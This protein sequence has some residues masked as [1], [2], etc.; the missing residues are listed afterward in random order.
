MDVIALIFV[1][2]SSFCQLI[3][4]ALRYIP[5]SDAGPTPQSRFHRTSP[6][7]DA[8][9]VHRSLIFLSIPNTPHQSIPTPFL[10]REHHCRSYFMELLSYD[11]RIRLN[12]RRANAQAYDND[13]EPSIELTTLPIQFAHHGNGE[14]DISTERGQETVTVIHVVLSDLCSRPQSFRQVRSVK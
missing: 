3:M 2:Y 7:P 12:L 10:H 8:S 9:Y 11:E 6:C 5:L 14:S 1:S 13:A 4:K